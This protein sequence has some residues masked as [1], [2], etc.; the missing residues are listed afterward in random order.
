MFRSARLRLIV[1]SAG[2][3]SLAV[4]VVLA[5]VFWTVNR[6]IETETR[7]VV[8][9]ELTGLAESYG[10]LGILGLSR[11]ID[12]RVRSGSDPDAVYLLTDGFGQAVAGNLGAWPPTVEAGGGWVELELIRTDN[13]KVVPISAASVQ[14]RGGER[15]LVGRDAS[16]RQR[17]DAILIQ[18]LILG[19]SAAVVVSLVIGWLLSRLVFSRLS[20]VADTAGEIISGEMARRIPLRGTGDE[21][22]RLAVTLNEMLDRIE[23]LIANLRMTTDSFAHDLRSPLTRLRVHIETLANDRL[24][25]DAKAH[26][27]DRSVS[28][29]DHLLRIFSDLTEIARAD[30]LLGQSEFET[31]DLTAL[32]REVADFAEP[33]AAETSIRIETN[34]TAPPIVGHRALLLRAFVNLV[35]NALRYAPPG[36][37]VSIGLST[38][39]GIACISVSDAGDGVPD[40]ALDTIFRPFVTLDESRTGG[41][42]GLGLAL[43]AAIARLHHGSATAANLNPGFRISLQIP[44]G[45][46]A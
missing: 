28:E 8:N 42:S 37:Q 29:I 9:A 41:A 33:L 6:I 12:R 39:G 23:D 22:D 7:S 21:F 5:L 19:L 40:S 1:I 34:G 20:E 15:L 44:L 46:G 36:S 24:D 45:S 30:A 18:S 14:L 17:F 31:V 11:T 3:G 32:I 25:G 4:A 27:L 13:E 2:L 38:S 26:A 43:V 35:E 10:D 16:A